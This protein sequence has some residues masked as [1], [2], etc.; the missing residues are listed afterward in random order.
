[1]GYETKI[2]VGCPNKF[3]LLKDDDSR[4]W[5]EVMAEFNCSKIGGG[6]VSRE[7]KMTG[8]PCYVFGSDGDTIITRDKYGESLVAVPIKKVIEGLKEILATDKYSRVQWA[9]DALRSMKKKRK[10]YHGMV[11]T[12]CIM[13]GY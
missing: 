9:Y 7:V 5:F 8:E 6:L 11:A 3:A 10:G 13:F 4:Q 1:M 2:Y 12:H